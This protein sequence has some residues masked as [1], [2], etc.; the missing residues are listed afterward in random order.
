MRG[1]RPR[2]P[3]ASPPRNGRRVASVPVPLREPEGPEEIRFRPAS[4][5]AVSIVVPVH[6]HRDLT[7]RCLAALAE[8]TP[9]ELIQVVVVDDG[10]DAGTAAA[11]RRVSG[12]TLVR[13]DW[14][15][16]FVD[17]CRCGVEE[18]RG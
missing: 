6:G 1:G 17:A 7:L 13:R 11:L 2:A 3:G 18:T 8:R 4:A 5:P 9:H 12:L 10:S 14:N 15:G 16:G